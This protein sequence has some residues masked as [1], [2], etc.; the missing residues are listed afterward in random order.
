MISL[1]FHRF[2]LMLLGRRATLQCY[3]TDDPEGSICVYIASAS[4]LGGD[5]HPK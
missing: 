5:G 1:A 4:I 2:R 3:K